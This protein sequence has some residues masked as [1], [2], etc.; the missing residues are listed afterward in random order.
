MSNKP[1]VFLLPGLMCDEAI[2]QHQAAA[3]A[4]FAD[5]RIPV[6]RGF[7]SLRDMA[8]SVLQQA[9][10]KFSVAG[11]SMGG[12]VVW[13]LLDLA[14]K[15][16]ERIAVMDS[17]VHPVKPGEKEK[18]EILLQAAQQ[19]GLQAVADAWIKPMLHPDHHADQKL[20]AEI[21]AMLLRNTITDFAG[22]I[23]ALLGREDRNEFLR[24]IEQKVW[25]LVGDQDG[26]STPAQHEHMQSLLPCSEL[27]IIRDA[28][29]MSTME[30]PEAASK[31]L[32]EWLHDK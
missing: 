3:L 21:T 17:G 32:V 18:R 5:V 9:P 6:F 16:I 8:T 23:Q 1:C 27:R 10:E 14:G 25:L 29:H 15:R 24:T 20:L 30:Q 13:E 2:W 28:G 7:T 31:L 22:Q 12:R 19:R 4:P 11:H 26:W